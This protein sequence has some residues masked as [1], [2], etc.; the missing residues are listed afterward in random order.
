[1]DKDGEQPGTER[2]LPTTNNSSTKQLHTKTTH[3]KDD[4]Q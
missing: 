1:M 3:K 2:Q 4:E